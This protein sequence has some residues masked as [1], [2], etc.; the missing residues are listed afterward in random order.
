MPRA[1]HAAR[2]HG[3]RAQAPLGSP[4]GLGLV[5]LLGAVVWILPGAL[6]ALSGKYQRVVGPGLGYLP[7]FLQ[8]FGLAIL[9]AAAVAWVRARMPERWPRIAVGIVVFQ[10]AAAMLTYESNRTVARRLNGDPNVRDMALLDAAFRAGVCD[11]APADATIWSLQPHP[12]MGG[13][14][15]LAGGHFSTA[16]GRRMNGLIGEP[17]PGWLKRNRRPG[18]IA[19]P[20]FVLNDARPDGRSAYV[21]LGVVAKGDAP[22]GMS[23]SLSGAGSLQ[24]EARSEDSRGGDFRVR[25][26]WLFVAG[27]FARLAHS[28]GR[29]AATV[30]ERDATG[31]Y[32]AP[33]VEPLDLAS[34]ETVSC[35]DQ[36]LVLAGEFAEAVDLSRFRVLTLDRD[37]A[38]VVRSEEPARR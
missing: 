2:R 17:A 22:A 37:D 27:N 24:N 19:P 9:A 30:V 23:P 15:D 28:P 20:T 25:R 14:P 13:G 5:A 33:V 11:A 8:A 4:P 32:V 29:L 16:L 6:L 1:L 38:S 12:W 31:D 26:F 35:S 3:T 7:V 10:A 18:E 34:L 36:G 21:I